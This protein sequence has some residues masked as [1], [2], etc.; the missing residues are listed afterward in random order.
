MS[1]NTQAYVLAHDAI[2]EYA[3]IWPDHI[4]DVRGNSVVEEMPK[5]GA[6]GMPGVLP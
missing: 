4:R 2:G 3:P 5:V 6:Y 1:T